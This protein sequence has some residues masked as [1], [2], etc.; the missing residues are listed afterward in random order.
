VDHGRPREIAP[1]LHTPEQ[2]KEAKKEKNC[3]STTEIRVS[4]KEAKEACFGGVTDEV[5]AKQEGQLK[6]G[7]EK[8]QALKERLFGK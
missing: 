3:S 8:T 1:F 2:C 6:S 4:A 7:T 5:H